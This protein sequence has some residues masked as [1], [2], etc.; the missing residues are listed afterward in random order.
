MWLGKQYCGLLPQGQGFKSHPCS[1]YIELV[2][3]SY[4]MLVLPRCSSLLPQLKR[5]GEMVSEFPIL[6]YELASRPDS[7]VL[8]ALYSSILSK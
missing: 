4:A 5:V 1:V 7:L 8:H 3:T 6:W 2:C